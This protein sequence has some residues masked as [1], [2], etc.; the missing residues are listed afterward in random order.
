MGLAIDSA[1]IGLLADRLS[2]RLESFGPDPYVQGFL[3]GVVRNE[4]N[5]PAT[6]VVATIPKGQYAAVV[7]SG[8]SV[9]VAKIDGV[10]EI[11]SL[12]SREE[13]DLLVW[14]T[15]QYMA[16]PPPEKVT[17]V[18]DEGIGNVRLALPVAGAGLWLGR[19]LE[20]FGGLLLV[21]VVGVGL[22]VVIPWLARL[23]SSPVAGSERPA[24]GSDLE[25]AELA[26]DAQVPDEGASR[27]GS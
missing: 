19:V 8:G 21:V 18:Y 23:L 13:V 25:T 4:G 16:F 1:E 24:E 2:W 14:S 6:S 20:V 15:S 17:L 11:G 27:P 22:L 10:V 7:R 9:D 26:A 5:R 12:R 3:R